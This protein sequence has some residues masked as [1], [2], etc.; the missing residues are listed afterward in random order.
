MEEKLKNVT[1]EALV[2]GSLF[3]KPILFIEYEGMLN[4]KYDFSDESCLFM[5][6]NFIVY[7]K[8]FSQELSETK[9]NTFITQNSELI[10]PYK[11][12]GGYKFV[13]KI[14]E[15]ANEDD[16]E[17]YVT[18]L[19]KYSLLRELHNRGFNVKKIIEHK[20][21]DTLS[22]DEIIKIINLRR[23]SF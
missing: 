12:L 9:F 18:T 4:E 10:E 13:N 17:N 16:F 15:M 7:Y 22:S 8:T 2:I 11:K 14:M 20:K 21:F 3:K 6:K 1:N 19:K 5:F 23:T